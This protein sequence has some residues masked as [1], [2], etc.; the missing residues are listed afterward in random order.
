MKETIITETEILTISTTTTRRPRVVDFEDIRAAVSVDYDDF[1]RGAPWEECDGFNHETRRATSD[2]DRAARGY[3][4]DNRAGFVVELLEDF[5]EDYDYYRK[6]GASK[7]TAA[8][9]VA[10]HKRS[11]TDLI[12]KWRSNGWENYCAPVDFMGYT[13]SIGGIDDYNFADTFYREELAANVAYQMRADG[14]IIENEPET[15]S[16]AVANFRNK[17]AHNRRLCCWID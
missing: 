4:S 13:D 2:D 11:T 16:A 12:V 6:N 14:F 5:R 17:L 8:E 15:E 9:M 1:D 7:Q 3:Y 10:L